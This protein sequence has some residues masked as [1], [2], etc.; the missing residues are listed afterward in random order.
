M[1]SKYDSYAK[2]GNFFFEKY[3]EGTLIGYKYYLTNNIPVLYEFGFGLSYTKFD[4]SNLRLIKDS[5]GSYIVK[6]D[7]K[8]TVDFDCHGV[9]EICISNR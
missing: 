4:Y 2:K 1:L 8:K 9:S 5:E 7:I 6:F 3:N